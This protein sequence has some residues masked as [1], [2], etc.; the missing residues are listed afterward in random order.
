[1][2]WLVKGEYEPR[3]FSAKMYDCPRDCL[4]NEKLVSDSDV[5]N[6]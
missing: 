1:M 2:V 3:S 5:A 6:K 4:F